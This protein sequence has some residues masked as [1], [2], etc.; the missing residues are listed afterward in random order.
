MCVEVVERIEI[1]KFV[2]GVFDDGTVCVVFDSILRVWIFAHEAVFGCVAFSLP[3]SVCGPSVPECAKVR[4]TNLGCYI[5]L[6][7][8]KVGGHSACLP[9]KGEI[10]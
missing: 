8:V 4:R 7:Y 9:C 2:H 3:T 5:F 6:E 1:E 10:V